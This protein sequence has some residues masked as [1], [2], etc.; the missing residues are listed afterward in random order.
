MSKLT[1]NTRR[2]LSAS[3]THS[4][5]GP[6]I[7]E[8]SCEIDSHADTCCLGVN[9]C[10]IYFTGKVCD[11]SPFLDTM[12]PQTNI[13]ICTGAT[14]YDDA[15]GN[16]KILVIN[17][18]LW[19]GD[20]MAHSLINP[21]QMRAIGV[22][23][24]DDPTALDRFFGIKHDL[25]DIPFR[26]RGSTCLFHTRTPMQWELDNCEHIELTSDTKWDPNDVIFGLEV[27]CQ[28]SDRLAR[29]TYA[30]DTR[31]RRPNLDPATLSRQW[32][33]GLETA[34]NTLKCTTQAGIRHAIHP[35]T[36]RYR[37]DY[38]ALR[39]RRL[40][41]TFYSDTLFTK[42]HSLHGYKCA[43][44]ITDGRFVHVYPMVSKSGAGDALQHFV[45]EVGI[46]DI[47]VTDNAP[48]LTGR[49][50]EFQKICRHYKVKTRQTEPYTPRQNQAELAIQEIK[51]RWRIKMTQHK[52][53]KRLWD[54]GLVWVSEITNRTARG[55][56][57]RTPYEVITGNT[58]DISEWLDFDFYDW[59][60]FWNVPTHELT[61]EKAE[62]GR[63]LGVAHRVGSDMCYWVLT[64]NGKV[65]ART[66]VQ[67]VT[68]DDLQ[69]STVTERMTHFNKKIKEK[70]N[71]RGHIIQAP[72]EG[73]ILDDKECDMND[74]PE[75]TTIPERDDFTDD[76]FDAYL[77][78]EL[79]IPHG[80]AYIRG[81]VMKRTRDEDG[82]PIGQ[83]HSN[84]L[85]DT[86]QY[87][88]QL[89][90]GSTS[91]Y[92]ANLIAENLFAQCDPDGKYHLVFKEIVDHRHDNTAV[93]KENGFL[94]GYNGNRHRIKTT[95]GWDIC[96]EWQDRSTSWL[97]LKDVKDANPVELADYAVANKLSDEPAFAWW[98]P[99]V[100]KRRNRIVNRLKS[101]YW[102]TTH[103][104]GIEIPKSVEHALQIDRE[105]GTDH[106]RKAI[107][108]EMK[109][110][111][112]A[113]QKW[114]GGGPDAARAASINGSLI[115]YQEIKCHMVFDIKMDGDLTR[116]AHLVAGGHTTETPSSITY[117]SVVL[118][119]SI[120]IAFLVAALNDLDI[121]AAD[122]GN[123]YLNAP[124]REKIWTTAGKEFGS[125]E[126]SVMLIVRALYSLKTSGASWRSTFAQ[127]WIEMG[128]KATR[129]D[130]DVWLRADVKPNGLHYY[131]MLLVYV[132]DI[133]LVSHQP[134]Q[135]MLEIQQLYR[136][137]DDLIGPPK[138][139]LGANIS[140]FQLPDGTEAWSASA[141][142]YIK[143]AVRNLE[144][145]LGHDSI[146]S[147][148]RNK[149]NRP[150]PLAY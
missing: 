148:L 103:K 70:M 115:G 73:L 13:E 94:H 11:V 97:P 127:K 120:R 96:V 62:L 82:N 117:S 57:A 12:T 147:K 92:T 124:C 76:A 66:T 75:Q 125:D 3:R 123:A 2:S 53:P 86:R 84:L 15:E 74:E 31:H 81:R 60:W 109:N 37:T 71:E 50:S 88:V 146:P 65:I 34:K 113:F 91:E 89:A 132:D 98:L 45:S 111:R 80:D 67:R 25:V 135:T 17:E 106:W 112:I 43:Q 16:T 18:A 61:E 95:K 27:E 32:G 114:E 85:L 35:L 42:V 93:T 139:Y 118:R 129:V 49:D 14:A 110:V 20:H 19:M 47:I 56:E 142:D 39:H 126:G 9:F 29:G 72:A 6:Q 58:P 138:R 102:R 33:I 38:M 44:V 55:P 99:E 130:P 36:R 8:A 64:D 52:V 128:Y 104:F 46:P 134:K 7:V 63:I 69:I 137:K 22:Q 24:N 133:L 144:E 143:T 141:R 116:K 26:M 21:Y 140:K 10:P 51:K 107:E 90:D 100:Q 77:G 68:K 79:M 149:V 41:T 54:Y 136:L 78:A 122:V 131:K 40:H 30:Y 108:K 83:W 121:F 119:E 87:K 101:R 23:L 48:E 150:L 28:T 59:C 105:T 4:A 1:T 5:R 145:V